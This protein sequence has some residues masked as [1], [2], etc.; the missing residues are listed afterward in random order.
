MKLAFF[1]GPAPLETAHGE[2]VSVPNGLE[3]TFLV[4]G[5]FE[6]AI[7]SFGGAVDGL[8]VELFVVL[9]AGRRV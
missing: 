3:E 8:T 5:L 2:A 6:E 1:I 4:T 7:K 9:F